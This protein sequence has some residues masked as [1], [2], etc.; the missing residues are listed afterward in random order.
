M[1]ALAFVVLA[2]SKAHM[3]GERVAAGAGVE[4]IVGPDGLL[5]QCGTIKSGGKVRHTK[6][7]LPG[8]HPDHV[9]ALTKSA[10][11]HVVAGYAGRVANGTAAPSAPVDTVPRA[12]H[13]RVVAE[14][15]RAVAERDAFRAQLLAHGVTPATD[16]PA[17]AKPKGPPPA[18][19]ATA[20][21][22]PAAPPAAPPETPPA[23]PPAGDNS[24]GPADIAAILG[25]GVG[26]L[27]ADIAAG[28]HDGRLQ[29]LREAEV[30]GKNRTSALAVIDARIKALAG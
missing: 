4:Y 30:A 9:K 26:K 8:V 16:A 1:A 6:A 14:R 13:D 24:T 11:I 27:G 19:P 21:A 12:E 3:R 5:Y 2:H 22:P 10:N 7:D 23:A 18:P 20:E 28:K 15:D 17:P 25:V 29:T